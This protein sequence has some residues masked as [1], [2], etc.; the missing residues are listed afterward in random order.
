M[1]GFPAQSWDLN[2]IENVWGVLDGK[3]SA[4]PGPRPTTPYGW[5][6]RVMRAW[7]SIDQATINKL[8]DDVPRRVA[9]VVAEKG[10]WLFK[11][12]TK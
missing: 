11:K 3:L 10:E 4:M 8:V 9:R 6:R 1:Q 2:I 7:A 12:G 5:R